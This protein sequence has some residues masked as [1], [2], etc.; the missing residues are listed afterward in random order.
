M[1]DASDSDPDLATQA[2]HAAPSLKAGDVLMQRFRIT[3]K[4]GEGAQASVYQAFDQL[5]ETDIAIKLV[6][7]DT[8]LPLKIQQ[9]RNEVMVARKIQHPNVIQVHDVFC[10]DER[11]FFTMA[12]ISGWPLQECLHEPL[13]K[14]Q[15]GQ[16][17]E[18]LTGAIAACQQQ[19][20]V[21]GD[22]KPDN[23]II[24]EDHDLL[25]IDF[26]IGS[27]VAEQEQLSGHRDYAAPEVLQSGK[28]SPQSDTYSAGKVLQLLLQNVQ[29]SP[30]SVTDKL[31]H[32]QQHKFI[33]QLTHPV[34]ERRPDRQNL[35]YNQQ[36]TKSIAG[37]AVL[38][39]SLLITVSLLVLLM[40]SHR[41]PAQ[42]A[43][44]DKA[45][46]QLALVEDDKVPVLK[47]ISELLRYPLQS[48]AGIALI[49]QEHIHKLRSNLALNP[50]ANQND[51]IA[52]AS[53][54]EADIVVLLQA[55]E[56][57]AQTVLL[58]AD[59]MMMP[60]NTRLF[61]VTESIEIAQLGQQLSNFTLDIHHKL[62]QIR[63]QVVETSNSDFLQKLPFTQWQD[64][65]LDAAEKL[66]LLQQQSPDFPGVWIA[67]AEQAWQ[68]G[69]VAALQ[70]QLNQL[71]KTQT[72]EEYWLLLGQYFQAQIDDNPT[73]AMQTV[74]RLI[75]LHPGRADLLLKRADVHLWL[76]DMPAAIAD[77]RTALNYTP[78]DGQIWFEVGKLRIMQ[79][80]IKQA[81]AQELTQALSA[82]RSLGDNV[83]EGLVL[84]AF[85]VAHLRLAEYQVAERYFQ[86]AL[87]LRDAQTQPTER[88]TTLANLANVAAINRH[89]DIAE[90][91]L[92]EASNLL[93][94]QGDL[95]QQAHVLDTLGFMLEEQG[96]YEEALQYYKEGLD[97]R[98]QAGNDSKKAES[99]SNVAYIH[100]LTGNFSLAQIFWQQAETLFARAKDEAF[101]LRT[102]QN[103][104]QLSLAKGDMRKAGEYLHRATEK[105][106][107][108]HSEADMINK[109]LFSYLHFR[110]GKLAPAME[111]LNS[112]KS[113][114]SGIGDSRALTE[115]QL[116]HAEVCLYIADLPCLIQQLDEVNTDFLNDSLEQ[117]AVYRW[118]S[119]A[120]L[121]H[122]PSLAIDE[123]QLLA[124]AL[125]YGP[126]PLLTELKIL[127]DLQERFKLASNSE[128]MQK[129]RSKIKPVYHS[130]WLH[131]LYLSA[132]DGEQQTELAQQLL[133]SSPYWR[134]HLYYSVL[135]GDAAQLKQ[136][137]LQ[138]QWL[139]QLT[140][141]QSHRYQGWYFD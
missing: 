26:G 97:I 33:A 10:D 20:L 42:L 44:S 35:R 71:A 7:G 29:L 34:A 75:T 9:L 99:M 56:V 53:T 88:A 127:L 24:T 66:R 8:A 104:A 15:F 122:E 3:A 94:D 55:S 64:H 76:S 78:Y 25:L 103:L 128:P 96:R 141:T 120:R 60:A 125:Q 131:W 65:T 114:A 102:W 11:V 67:G 52:I 51:R 1:Y 68:Q 108:Q 40:N 62:K 101:L 80:E 132:R 36:N 81:I 12:L 49:S 14:K 2:L 43:P 93:R 46:W 73:L 17:C 31:W 140:E 109:L 50:I 106:D 137:E 61:S 21:H 85:G 70:L 111:N 77:Y 27:S 58:Q 90:Q 5:L 6:H 135:S 130:A 13:S 48:D 124:S 139:A 100:F 39:L 133:L 41:E 138:Q 22:I 113:M 72:Q 69:D 54:L 87:T 47:S 92:A 136:T 23:I 18:Q 126:V 107:A 116:W 83:G 32:R 19:Q 121:K 16:W 115:I 119:S 105:L 4:L 110:Q 28:I 37:P 134:S 95:E 112:A 84:N 91:A 98:V 123:Q 30:L 86:D 82:F 79:G 59:A 117:Q 89:F 45:V 129:A 74:N 118:L 57:N 63:D 38:L